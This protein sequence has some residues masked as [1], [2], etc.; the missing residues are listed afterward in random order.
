METK[1]HTS[2]QHAILWW[3]LLLSELESAASPKSGGDA[4]KAAA[5]RV[6]AVRRLFFELVKDSSI[7]CLLEVGAHQAETSRRFIEL[8]PGARAVAYEA[9][10]AIYRAALAMGLPSGMTLEN[11]A[12]GA[13]SGEARFFVPKD[14]GHREWG[15]TRKRLLNPVSV[16]EIAVPMI[17]LAEAGARATAGRTDRNAA[18]WIDVEGSVLDVLTGGAAFLRQQVG[19]IYTEV[20]DT[21]VYENSGTILRLLELLLDSGFIPVARDNQWRWAWNLLVVHEDV[22]YANRELLS[23][24]YYGQ[25]SPNPKATVEPE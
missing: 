16:Q 6:T 8:K 19:V 18:L 21:A 4:G 9:A 17:T 25:K 5:R 10:P 1:S 24:W 14:E 3:R 13:R 2:K 11:C 7:D 15:S 22:F 20:Y 23:G 12:I